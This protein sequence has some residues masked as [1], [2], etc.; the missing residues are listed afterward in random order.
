MI[1]QQEFKIRILYNIGN[2]HS[3]WVRSFQLSNGAYSWKAANA[4]NNAVIIGADHIEAVYQ[5]GI[6]Y[7][8]RW[9]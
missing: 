9:K 7:R 8:L 4:A 6:R 5:E 2:S 1:L 3:F